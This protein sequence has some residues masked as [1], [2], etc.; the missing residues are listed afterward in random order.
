MYSSLVFNSNDEPYIA[1][2]DSDNEDLKIAHHDGFSWTITTIDSNGSVGQFIDM[3]IDCDDSSAESTTLSID[4][5]CD[6]V[7]T[8]DDCDD[9]DATLPLVDADCDGV[10]TADDCDDSDPILGSPALDADC[11]GTLTEEDCDDSDPTL[12]HADS[13]EDGFTSCD[14]DC[15]DLDPDVLPEDCLSP[16]ATFTYE[17]SGSINEWAV[18]LGVFRIDVVGCGAQGGNGAA[19]TGSESQ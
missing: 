6:G 12:S 14:G 2:Y 10:L 18:P 19:G 5:D 11:D 9:D 7:L 3:A 17:Y 8:A 16:G 13:D 15:D 4:G 1:Y